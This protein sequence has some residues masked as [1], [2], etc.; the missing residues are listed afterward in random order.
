MVAPAI[1]AAGIGAVSSLLGGIFNRRAQRRANAAN[2]PSGQVAAWEAAG[3]NPLV[4]IQSGAFNPQQ[5]SSFGDSFAQSGAILA[6]GMELDHAEKLK[7]TA[8]QT[9]NKKLRD[10]LDKL[11]TPRQAGHLQQYGGI[12]PLPSQGIVSATNQ[13][14]S[15]SIPANRNDGRHPDLNG[16][17]S[18]IA[19]DREVEVAPFVSGS[20][21]TEISNAFTNLFG[22]PIIVPGDDGE[23][24]GIDEVG[25]AIAA[26]VP[27]IA[28]RGLDQI[29]AQYF[30][31]VGNPFN[32][33]VTSD[34]NRFR[35]RRPA[36]WWTDTMNDIGVPQSVQDWKPQTNSGPN[37]AI[38]GIKKAI[39][40]LSPYGYH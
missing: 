21:T 33:I 9:Q 3:I 34:I 2:S 1:A 35:E 22:G 38:V 26:G 10:Q 27:Q 7:K 20:G 32:D 28:Y 24:W 17:T 16:T 13:K 31:R 11:A 30:N 12:L 37:K 15:T 6:R 14:A 25:V 36:K 8:L 5:S 19:P 29:G 40:F 39:N 18:Y 4:G 23:P